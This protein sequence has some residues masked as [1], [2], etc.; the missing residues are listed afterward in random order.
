MYASPRYPVHP[1]EAEAF[2]ATQRHGTLIALVGD[3]FPQVSILPFLKHGD[4][5]ELHC[6]Q[7][8]PTFAAVR[9]NPRVTFLVSD[10]LA[11]SP[12]SWVDA[13]DAGRATLNFRAVAYE[14]EASVS[15]DPND[16]ATALTR[17]LAAYEPNEHYEPIHEGSLYA[18]RIRRLAALQLHVVRSH[19]KFKVGPAA[20]PGDA[21]E[22]V[23]AGLRQ[24]LQPGDARAADVIDAWLSIHADD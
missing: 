8:D 15:T 22:R 10:F 18:A 24:R 19:A 4:H 6:V 16:V 1:G 20:P 12:H 13:T 11:F 3:G 5:I 17:L 14:C 2:V 21:R 23:A 9:L 7:A